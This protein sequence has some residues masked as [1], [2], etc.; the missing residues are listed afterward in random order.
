MNIGDIV[1]LE[2]WQEI[3]VRPRITFFR[4]QWSCSLKIWF[5]FWKNRVDHG[6]AFLAFGRVALSKHDFFCNYFISP[7]Y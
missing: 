2:G 4:V 6:L 1:R 5:I 3:G 7:A